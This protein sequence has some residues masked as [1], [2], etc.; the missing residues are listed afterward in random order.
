[1]AASA[2]IRDSLATHRLLRNCSA[3]I[4]PID[5]PVLCVLVAEV[6]DQEAECGNSR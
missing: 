5:L 6:V 4:G 2:T 3:V 1:M